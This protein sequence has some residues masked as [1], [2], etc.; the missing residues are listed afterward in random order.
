MRLHQ[1]AAVRRAIGLA[2]DHVGMHLRLS[3]AESNVTG[4][5]KDFDLFVEGDSFVVFSRPIE[6]SDDDI[7]ERPDGSE[8]AAAQMI[9]L[10]KITKSSDDLIAR[11]ENQHKRF[12]ALLL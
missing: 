1:M 11:V 3:R 10:G 4:Q 2:D 8:M 5:R 9:L 12:L 6:V 7:A